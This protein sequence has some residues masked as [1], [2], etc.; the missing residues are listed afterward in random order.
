MSFTDD[1]Q[2]VIAGM[3]PRQRHFVLTQIPVPLQRSMLR[4]VLGHPGHS[5]GPAL[6][7]AAAGPQV[8]DNDDAQQSDEGTS[9]AVH[10]PPARL[11]R[12]MTCPVG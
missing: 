4:H 2:L 11:Y 6:V 7:R 10:L 8:A 12:V 1:E 5:P 3:S 9:S